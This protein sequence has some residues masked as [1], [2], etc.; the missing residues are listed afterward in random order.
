[1]L[2]AKG[3]AVVLAFVIFGAG[4]VAGIGIERTFFSDKKSALFNKFRG[5]QRFERLQE[6]LQKKFARELNL[7][8]QQQA[9][10]QDILSRHLTQIKQTALRHD[11]EIEQMKEAARK[12]FS[13]ILTPAQ[14]EKFWKKVEEAKARRARGQ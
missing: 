9:Q 4:V 3:T 6:H 2:K 12:E 11:A 1:M 14:Q 13:G 8:L 5:P 10:L 7:S